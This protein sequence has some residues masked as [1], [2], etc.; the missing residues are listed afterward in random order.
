M[1]RDYAPLSSA[2]SASAVG[3]FTIAIVGG[4]F[5]GTLLAIQLLRMGLA[6]TDSVVLIEQHPR[7]G[8]GLAYSIEDDC[9]LLNVPAGNMSALADDPGH[10]VRYCQAIDSLMT[11]SS[12]VP[13]RLYGQYLEQLLRETEAQYPQQLHRL[14]GSVLD[15]ERL[16][17]DQYRLDF[18]NHASIQASKVVLALGHF[19]SEPLAA[20]KSL[21]ADKVIAPWDAAQFHKIP[22]ALPIAILGTGHTAIDALLRLRA[23][24]AIQKVYLI[25]RRGLLPNS[26]R[27]AA[28]TVAA[29]FPDWLK[30]VPATARSYASALRGQ[31]KKHSQNGGDW[32]D[33]FNQIRAHTADLWQGLTINE[34]A[35]FLRQLL[36]YWDVHR[37]R[38]APSI[39]KQI[40]QLQQQGAIDVIAG[41]IELAHMQANQINLQY[42]DRAT[43]EMKSLEVG[44]IINCTGPNYDLSTVPDPLVKSLIRRNY[45]QQDPL[46]LSLASNDQYQLQSAQYPIQPGL[47]YIGPMLKA[48]YWEAIAVPELRVHVQRL[49]KQLLLG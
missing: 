7:T 26:H 38:L 13:R 18:A 19:A 37:H 28:S 12:F 31:I 29:E 8:P 3:Q 4:G 6:K 48:L 36:P 2:T 23:N 9:C 47:Y 27:P 43:Q 17:V 16:A 45:L 33:V 1:E 40:E 20:L 14:H 25:S 11:S 30:N 22:L 5:S 46:K 34:R 41:R 24:A 21:P 10:F 32:R 42:R 49:A 15:L 35:R 44:A 39:G